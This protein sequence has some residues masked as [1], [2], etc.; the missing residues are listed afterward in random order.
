MKLIIAVVIISLTF[1]SCG[2]GYTT[3]T[4]QKAEK[5]SLKFTGN[6]QGI[7]I[8]IDNA[9]QIAYDPKIELYE[10][11]PGKHAVK[12]FRNNQI[13]V[14]RVVIVDNHTTF[15]IDVP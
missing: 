12:I 13:I 10:L 9:T 6:T 8:S 5:G 7:S 11:K 4:I 14:D 15:E 1:I 2:G 3:G